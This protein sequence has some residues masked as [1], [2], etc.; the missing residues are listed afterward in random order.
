M[1]R[2]SICL[3]VYNGAAHLDEALA[4]I[5]AQTSRDYVVLASDNASTDQTSEIFLRWA[6]RIPM[7]IVTQPQTIP[8]Q[9]HFNALLN[10]VETESYMLL[11]HDDYFCS[12]DAVAKALDILDAQ[13]QVS[14]IYCDLA[15]VSEKGRILARRHF[16]RSGVIK[17]DAI[18]RQCIRKAR[19]M[20]GIPLLVRRDALG[21]NRYD[22]RFRYVVDVDLSWTVSKHAPAWH[23]PEVLLANRYSGGNSTWAML[24]DAGNE[25]LRLAHKHGIHLTP[26]DRARIKLTNW[27]V[28][29]TKR[30]FGLYERLVTRFG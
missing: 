13:P 9:E 3:P 24:A 10:R 30:L 22:H 17:A 5:S 26:I 21:A 20:F 28:A 1:A 4:S 6:K 7:E 2:V 14:A 16:G 19:N 8:M 15:Y 27:Q 23:I 11:C 29:Q 25:F 18:G 12:P